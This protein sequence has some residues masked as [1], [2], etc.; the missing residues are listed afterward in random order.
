[1]EMDRKVAFV[2]GANKS[3]GLEV[4]RAL[5]A[6][7]MVVYLGSRDAAAGEEAARS[8]AGTGDVRPVHLD[9]M[10][11]PTLSA[12]ID[13]IAAEQG[14]LDALVNNAGI[15]PGGGGAEACPREQIDIAMQTNALGPARLIQLAV[16]LLRKSDAPRVVNV[17]SRAGSFVT[18]TNPYGPMAAAPAIP[19]AYSLSKTAANS[20]TVLFA[21]DLKKYDIRVNAVCPGYVKSQVSRFMGTLTP[22]EGSRVVIKYA[23]MGD[24][25]PTG[26]FFSDEGPTPW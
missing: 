14:R 5:A 22:E 25:C 24:D 19:F 15:A 23:T 11:A 3:I 13:R 10:D 1:M 17:T 6:R 26:G 9:L 20:M 12:A 18:L 21:S 7:G 16:P 2:T 4:V 8:L